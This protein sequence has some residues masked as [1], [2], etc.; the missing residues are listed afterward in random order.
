[1]NNFGD[2]VDLFLD[3]GQSI[4][5]FL[6]VVAFLV[7]VLGVA[8]FIR[9]SDSDKDFNEKKKFLIW[10]TLGMFILV[11]IWGIISFLKGEFGFGGNVGVPQLPT[12]YPDVNSTIR[13]E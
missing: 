10:G 2:I 8:R 7:F 12:T 9:S 1:M 4:I 3:L 13:F 6:A 11:T 5:P